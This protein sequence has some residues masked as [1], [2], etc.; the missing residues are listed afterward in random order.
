L[1]I[2]LG[3]NPSLRVFHVGKFRH[4]PLNIDFSTVSTG[5]STI[6]KELP[7]PSDLRKYLFSPE[8]TAPTPITISFLYTY[9]NYHHPRLLGITAGIPIEAK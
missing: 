4:T 3:V 9:I 7:D 2:T 5:L 6:Y 1:G 8:S